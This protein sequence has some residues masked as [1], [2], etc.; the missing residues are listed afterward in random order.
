MPNTLFLQPI[1]SPDNPN[2]NYAS[3]T[4]G[5]VFSN[6]SQ[7]GSDFLTPTDTD[8]LVNQGVTVAIANAEAVFSND[9]NFSALFT[10]SSVISLEGASQANSSSEAKVIA[11][12]SV[13]KNET[14]SFDFATDLQIEAKEIENRR[15]EYNHAQGKIS[16]LI[17]E[18]SDTKKPK[19][20][21]FF[22][23]NGKL[24]SADRKGD[25]KLRY[26]PH[27]NRITI[28]DQNLTRDIDGNNNKDLLTGAVSGHYE[29]KF[30]HDLKI[31]VVELSTSETKLKQDTLIGQL[32]SDVTYGTIWNDL[33]FGNSAPNK[34]YGS[35]G[36]D[37][38]YAQGGDDILEGGSGNDKLDG[39]DKNDKIY[40]GDGNDTLIG[41]PGDDT[42]VGGIGNDVMRGNQGK[43]LFLFHKDDSLL[44]GELDIIKDFKAD[45]AQIK[46]QGWGTMNASDLL[47]GIA[48]SPFQIADTS[49]GTLLSSSSGGKVLLEG[50]KVNQL[51]VGN[52]LFS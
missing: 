24:I 43:D 14:F 15:A 11:S 48:T 12:F 49:D 29:R 3:A 39:G 1:S 19:V 32:G 26:S 31:T 36:D 30:N 44:T 6:Y 51:N 7:A 20:L 18:T 5:A 25:L 13:A 8:T 41:G 27:Q 40:G 46:L 38:L 22:G 52:F 2:P 34:M 42:L 9:P 21:D 17:L 23:M 10:E 37:Q 4:G 16:F 45:K 35:L 50:V 28:N 33:T 47:Q